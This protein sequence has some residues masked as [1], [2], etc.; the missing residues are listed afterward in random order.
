MIDKPGLY[1]AER[2]PDRLY[3]ADPVIEPSL[4]SSIAKLLVTRS[5]LHAWYEHPRLNKA[6]VPETR[7]PSREMN[8]G[9]AAH[10]LI[11]GAGAEVVEIAAD[12]FK[13]KAAREERDAVLRRGGIPISSPDMENVKE[14]ATAARDQIAGYPELAG[15]LEK[16]TAE[17][18]GVWQSINGIWCRMRVDW[19]PA[20]AREGG[21]ITLVDLKTTSGSAHPDD[22]Q[23][24]AFD[25]GYDFQAAHYEL[26]AQA[27]IPDVRSVRFVFIV[28]EQE[29][30]YCMSVNEFGGQAR[31]EA[32]ELIKMAHRDWHQ[33][34]TRGE[35]PG[36]PLEVSHLDPPKWRSERAE[37][38]RLALQRRAEI[39]QRPL[40]LAAP[41]PA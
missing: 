36:Y 14:L 37:V 40:E 6:K 19:L 24:T 1:D 9:S 33:C 41:G 35:W 13:T 11:L 25:L 20:K 21:H 8:I 32:E 39:W 38:R 27:L 7:A 4:S 12:H 18:T 10:R 26:G 28:I 15:L 34:I 5:P 23:R 2:V 3:H 30:P 31:A 22:W 29:A 17:V 16:G